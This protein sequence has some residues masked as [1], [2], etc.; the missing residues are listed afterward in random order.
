MR[1]IAM[2]NFIV[3]ALTIFICL[4]LLC[5]LTLVR[6]YTYSVNELIDDLKGECRTV[7]PSALI[8]MRTPY[9]MD[10]SAILSALDS[11][12]SEHKQ[13]IMIA[14]SRGNVICYADGNEK[15]T[16]NGGTLSQSLVARISEGET[17]QEL[18]TLGGYY[19]NKLLN[20][21]CPITDSAG[22]V[23]GSVI[24]STPISRV[25]EPFRAIIGSILGGLI[26]V[27]LGSFAMIYYVSKR[28]ARPLSSM[29]RAAKRFA[30]G[31]FSERV[32]VSGPSEISD[33][34]VSFNY[35]AESMEQLESLRSE[36]IA[37]VSHELKTPM[38]TISGLV[39]GMLD[40]T[41]PPERT[42]HY[43][44]IVSGEVQR[45]SRLVTK[46]LFATKLQSG[47]QRLNMT[48]IDICEMVTSTLFSMEKTIEGKS[49][50]VGIDFESDRINV[51]ADCDGVS[52][53][54]NNLIDNAVK[55]GNEG[56]RLTVSVYKKGEQAFI[57]V[58]NTGVG[59]EVSE[60]PYIFDRF[61]KVDRSRGLDKNSTGLGL[62]IT[63]SILSR[64]GQ[65]ISVESEYGRYVRFTFT[66][67]LAKNPMLKE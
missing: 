23:R 5:S 63:K 50:E 35:M 38:T 60:I 54:L 44:G 48:N 30:M 61:Y 2:Q 52:Q 65:E 31:D 18:G 66:L 28:L 15:G 59:I 14:D 67:P 1:N 34:A 21:A 56:G 53:V 7:A 37:N 64:M 10:D 8:W 49:M 57:S 13:R 45:L 55:Y 62:Y 4:I 12:A 40:G 3:T 11:R 47:D 51:L 22:N 32:E 24:I 46:L 29:S 16:Q 17:V 42:E 6:I 41:I 58:F 26:F 9:K 36:F 25:T 27:L 33:L 43:L 19:V 39:D 20:V